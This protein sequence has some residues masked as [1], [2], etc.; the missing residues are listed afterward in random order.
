MI[1]TLVKAHFPGRIGALT[2]AYTTAMAVGMAISAALAAPLARLG[3]GDN[4]RLGLGVWAIVSAVSIVPW[5][6]TARGS[7]RRTDAATPAHVPLR[8]LL[9]SRL[10]WA[11]ALFFATQSLQAYV[12]F[13]W[14]A[15]FF[16][17]AGFDAVQAGV[18]LAV[19]SALAI[20]FSLAVPLV[21]AR[22]RDHRL[23]I[24]ILIGCYAI[25]YIGMLVAPLAGAWLWAVLV[26]I[27]AACFPL[28]LTLIPMRAKSATGTSA[29][30]AFTQ[31]VG[32]LI[33]GTGPLLVGVLYGITGGWGAPFGLLFAV[34]AVQTL[35]G[36]QVGR[37][38][39]IEDELNSRNSGQHHRLPA[40]H[41]RP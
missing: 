31:S 3:G 20:P 28:A 26:G 41:R 14:F 4:W 19:L 37:R 8:R 36:W 34:L 5:L 18:W 17:D 12:A 35:A 13:G 40:A 25:A 27:G 24:M 22:L 39:S 33:A 11:M 6:V 7:G 21:A 10:A 32:Y 15:Q 2:A 9:R 16:R 23:L 30:S 1:P 38:R 29:L